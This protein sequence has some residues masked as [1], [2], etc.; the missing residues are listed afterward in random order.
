MTKP[1]GWFSRRHQTD[2]AHRKAQDQRTANEQR[3]QE[4]I[5]AQAADTAARKATEQKQGREI[6]LEKWRKSHSS[7]RV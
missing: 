4:L 1:S 2:A 7:G 5:D 3:K 6:P